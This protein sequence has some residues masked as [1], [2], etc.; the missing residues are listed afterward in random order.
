[1][2]KEPKHLP[3]GTGIPDWQTYFMNITRVVKT[4]GNCLLY[5]VGAVLVQGKK[6]IATGYNGTPQGVPNCMEGGCARCKNKKLGK[7][8]SGEHKGTCLC[9]HAE[10]NSLLQCARYGIASEGAVMYT[11]TSP[12]MLC[13][14]EMLNAG[15][16]AVYYEI[17]DK[18][19]SESLILLRKYMREVKQI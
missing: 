1:M 17:E 12:C 18:G 8:A 13:A 16:K 7:I 4:R 11:T 14:K 19:E 5:Q 6:I 15:I 10:I 2:K 9:V 3:K